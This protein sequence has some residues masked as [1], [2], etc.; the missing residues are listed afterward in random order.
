[1]DKASIIKISFLSSLVAIIESVFG[2]I[3][4]S[5]IILFFLII[6]DTITGIAVAVKYGSFN[7][8]GLSRL[9]KKTITYGAAI[10]TVRLLEI[11]IM[12]FL[13]TEIISK[14][15]VAFLQ[16]TE[17]ISILENL[18]LLGVPLP[19][20]FITFLLNHIKIPG[21][22]TAIKL[23][24]KS[25]NNEISEIDDIIRYQI[26]AFEDK[27]IK[28][29]LRIKFKYWKLVAMQ[30]SKVFSTNGK[31]DKEHLYY[32]IMS[33]IEKSTNDMNKEIKE[34]NIPKEYIKRFDSIY[35]PCFDKW[36]Q[37]LK[38]ICYSQQSV[39]EKKDQIL[40]NIIVLSY[41]MILAAHKVYNNNNYN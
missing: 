30:I 7:S 36:I 18:T 8:K 37:E 41:K 12:T 20:N 1:M 5:Y 34:E 33:L 6:L 2:N 13:E 38:Q 25:Q 28:K 14:I 17:T 3:D 29:L 35:K 21:L 40:N 10:L 39:S 16:V 31:K 11:G 22:N 15:L 32:K 19:S 26:P 27:E 24:I 4:V 23:G 9:V